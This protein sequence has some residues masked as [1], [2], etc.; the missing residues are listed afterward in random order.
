MI[1]IN[2]YYH[3]LFLFSD[4]PRIPTLLYGGFYDTNIE[5]SS[6]INHAAKFFI[7]PLS[8]RKSPIG[9][10]YKKPFKNKIL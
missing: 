10:R 7:A 8:K 5:M 3:E 2:E 1:I 9:S 6:T 4:K